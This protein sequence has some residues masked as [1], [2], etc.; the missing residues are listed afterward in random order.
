MNWV[1]FQVLPSFPGVS[2]FKDA[3]DIARNNPNLGIGVHLCLDGNL[4]MGTD[5]NTLIPSGSGQFYSYEQI[6]KKRFTFPFDPDEIFRKML[7]YKL[8]QLWTAG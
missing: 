2:L 7:F 4:N 8:S 5:Y 3:I 1:L 6:L